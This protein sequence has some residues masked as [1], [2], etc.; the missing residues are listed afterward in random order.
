VPKESFHE[1]SHRRHQRKSPWACSVGNAVKWFG[2]VTNQGQDSTVSQR[3]KQFC[4]AEELEGETWVETLPSNT[5]PAL[6]KVERS[7]TQ[8]PHRR[9]KQTFLEGSRNNKEKGPMEQRAEEGASPCQ[10]EVSLNGSSKKGEKTQRARRAAVIHTCSHN[11][12]ERAGA[13]GKGLLGS[14][15]RRFLGGESRHHRSHFQTTSPSPKKKKKKKWVKGGRHDSIR[16]GRRRLFQCFSSWGVHV[17]RRR[18]K[19]EKERDLEKGSE[20]DHKKLEL[21]I[22]RHR[23][24]RKRASKSLEGGDLW[25][26]RAAI[27]GARVG[28]SRTSLRAGHSVTALALRKQRYKAGE[29]KGTA[30]GGQL[31]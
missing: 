8:Q 12:K 4:Q 24:T 16:E 14:Q 22:Q 30:S 9:R 3:G 1:R 25:S 17:F 11:E 13:K 5:K 31:S 6:G 10:W 26:L 28:R 29:G 21:S 27:V 7:S 20:S 19:Q 15:Q 2:T 18:R 23:D